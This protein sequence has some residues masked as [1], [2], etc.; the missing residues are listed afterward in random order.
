ML[1]HKNV[2]ELFHCLLENK[3]L[4][5]IMEVA[6][7]G[8][9]YQFV[10]QRKKLSETMS[11]RIIYQVIDAISYCHERRVVHR[12][13]KLENVLFESPPDED[14]LNIKV[15]DFG[16]AGVVRPDGGDKIDAGSLAYM[17]PE[18]F[19]EGGAETTFAIDVWA[20][21]IMFYAMIYGSLPFF[22]AKENKL[23]E[24]I[25]EQPV[26]FDPKVA[27]TNE[28][29]DIMRRMLEKDP[30]KRLKLIEVMDMDYY[31]LED[32]QIA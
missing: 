19:Q 23:I 20:I 6:T 4:I 28:A 22:N 13:L 5:M 8:E 24:M 7:G 17:P 2:I 26:K 27:V 12:D 10:N 14:N 25:V 16:I 30:T 15:I 1:R 3:T 9:V 31:K 21:G 11:R 32:Q 29:K 18:C